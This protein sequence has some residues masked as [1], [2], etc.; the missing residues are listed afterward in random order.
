M[1][2]EKSELGP[3]RKAR[4]QGRSTTSTS[5]GSSTRQQQGEGK[6][7]GTGGR[8]LCPVYPARGGVPTQE[9]AKRKGAGQPARRQSSLHSFLSNTRFTQSSP[10]EA[11]DPARP[12]DS[13]AAS[14]HRRRGLPTNLPIPTNPVANRSCLTTAS[15]GIL[16]MCPRRVSRCASMHACSDGTPARARSRRKPELGVRREPGGKQTCTRHRPKKPRVHRSSG[17]PQ[18]NKQTPSQ[19]TV[20][21][22]H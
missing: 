15:S 1:Q 22:L 12:S 6:G 11:G 19:T 2:S 3:A 4:K 9:S 20:E 17:I 21:P 16:A 8:S 13:R 18:A 7:K 5:T 14:I 10:R